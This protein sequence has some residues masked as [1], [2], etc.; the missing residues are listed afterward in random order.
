MEGWVKIHRKILDNPVVCKDSDT[1]AIWIYLIINATHKEIDMLFKGKRITL[2]EGQLITGR[3]S[4]AKKLD[5]AES[6]VQ[7]ILKMF[8]IEHQIEQQTSSQNRLI[9]ILNWHKYQ[10]NEQQIEQRV[11]NDRTTSEQRVNTNKNERIKECK[12]INLIN[13]N[14]EKELKLFDSGDTFN[15]YLI[16]QGYT[17][18]SFNELSENEQEMITENYILRR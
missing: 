4:I 15:Q 11:N 13:L 9:S 17:E 10:D 7:R 2:K 6:K 1:L 12:N 14:K 18:D 8:E 16:E 3:K 5:I